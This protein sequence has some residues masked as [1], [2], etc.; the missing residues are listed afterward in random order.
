M[1]CKP[2]NCTWMILLRWNQ[3][4]NSVKGAMDAAESE[5]LEHV[6]Q[7]KHQSI[8]VLLNVFS[9]ASEKVRILRGPWHAGRGSGQMLQARMTHGVATR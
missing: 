8:D 4:G 3:V 2:V 7:F 5:A 1:L 9:Q 6:Q